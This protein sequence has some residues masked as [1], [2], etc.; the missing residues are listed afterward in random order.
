[1]TGDSIRSIVRRPGN[2][3]G[4]GRCGHIHRD[5]DSAQ[6]CHEN[7]ISIAYFSQDDKG[8]ILCSR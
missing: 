7:T 4:P 8:V 5:H 3:K 2:K 1:M 6:H